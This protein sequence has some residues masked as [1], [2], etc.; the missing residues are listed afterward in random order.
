M[1]GHRNQD[2]KTNK[3]KTKDNV[4]SVQKRY[5]V[6]LD[7]N[8]NRKNARVF[9][10]R[11]EFLL[12]YQNIFTISEFKMKE[13]L[14]NKE[15]LVFRFTCNVFDYLFWFISSLTVSGQLGRHQNG[16]QYATLNGIRIRIE[17]MGNVFYRHLRNIIRIW[18]NDVYILAD[19]SWLSFRMLSFRW[20]FQKKPLAVAVES[21]TSLW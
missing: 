15:T 10:K 12:K 13:L 5:L 18:R 20:L 7:I 21:L 11:G 17:S 14:W 1:H 8:I 19:H 4:R 16:D 3:Q 2:K 6:Y 9:L